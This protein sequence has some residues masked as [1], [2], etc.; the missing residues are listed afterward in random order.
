MAKDDYDVIVYKIL[1]YFYACMKRVIS[2][3]QTVFDKAIKRD[4]LNEEYFVS[5]LHMM[6]VEG[7]ITNLTIAKPWGNV[8]LLAS[9]LWD[10]E[11]TAE[12][13]RYLKE[14]SRAKK[15]RDT[16]KAFVKLF[17]ELNALDV[18]GD[19]L[20]RRLLKFF[21]IVA[22]ALQ[23]FDGRVDVLSNVFSDFGVGCTRLVNFVQLDHC[24]LMTGFGGAFKIFDGVL[25]PFFQQPTFAGLVTALGISDVSR[26]FETFFCKLKITP[27]S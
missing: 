5:I 12:G 27:V 17:G 13:I 2:F 16:L 22:A 20:Q 9:D 6:Q 21:R 7:L 23:P 4:V 18:I 1:L 8:Y 10:A 24:A 26:L 11:I 25:V 3:D 15:A 19:F 14:N